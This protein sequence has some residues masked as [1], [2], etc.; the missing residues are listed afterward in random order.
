MF[1]PLLL[2]LLLYLAAT[3]CPPCPLHRP[4]KSRHVVTNF[5]PIVNLGLIGVNDLGQKGSST[6]VGHKV[7]ISVAKHIFRDGKIIENVTA[8]FR[9]FHLTGKIKHPSIHG[10]V[11]K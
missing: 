3:V 9:P 5:N 11:H 2:N 7:T 1:R 4:V 10:F 8:F 6:F